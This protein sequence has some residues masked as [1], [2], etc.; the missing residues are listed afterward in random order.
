M[1]GSVAAT[2]L[3]VGDVILAIGQT[4]VSRLS[5]GALTELIKDGGNDLLFLISRY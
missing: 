5:G 1:P 2:A 3:V 4:D